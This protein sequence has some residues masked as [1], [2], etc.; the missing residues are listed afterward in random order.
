[1]LNKISKHKKV[2]LI[3]VLIKKHSER[4][5]GAFLYLFLLCFMFFMFLLLLFIISFNYLSTSEKIAYFE[6]RD[7][8]TNF[9]IDIHK[10][11]VTFCGFSFFFRVGFQ[12]G[13]SVINIHFKRSKNSPGRITINLNTKKPQGNSGRGERTHKKTI[14]ILARIITL[15]IKDFI[16]HLS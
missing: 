2:F 8:C 3:S 16:L 10:K 1:M 14:K 9:P 11:G 12:T 4:E 7:L 13:K 15:R 5:S 6:T